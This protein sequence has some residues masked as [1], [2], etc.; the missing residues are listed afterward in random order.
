MR[1]ERMT[2]DELKRFLLLGTQDLDAAHATQEAARRWIA[3]E[4]Q[5]VDDV[6]EAAF[7]RGRAAGHELGYGEGYE[8]GFTAAEKLE[9]G[10]E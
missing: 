6:D 4:Q 7:E 5:D 8:D 3:C 1:F 9:V 10:K 2:D